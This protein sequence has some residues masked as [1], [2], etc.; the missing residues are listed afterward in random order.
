MADTNINKTE[1][2]KKNDTMQREQAKAELDK[3]R[4]PEQGSDT[5][6]DEKSAIGGGETGESRQSQTGQ[7]GQS[8]TGQGGQSSTGQGG[9]QFD[10]SREPTNR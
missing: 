9:Q 6:R 5:E 3:N 4:K 10:K 1:D 2:M 7:G 8:S